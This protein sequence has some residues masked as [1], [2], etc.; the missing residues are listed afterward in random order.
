MPIAPGTHVVYTVQPGDT[1]YAI[2]NRLGTSVPALVQ[3]NALYPPVTEPDLIFPGQVILARV[4]GMSQQSAVLHQVAPGDTMYRIAERYDSTVDMLA[5][6]NRLE[7]PDILSV[8]QLIFIPAFV[9]EVEPGDTLFRISRRFGLPL[10]VLMRA[11]RNRP[12]LS[13]DVIYPGFRL[14]VPLPSSTNIAVFQPLPGT[15]IVPG[16]RLSGVARA[17]EANV[18]Y[19]IRDDA[20]RVVARERAMTASEGAP[21]FG[22]FDVALQFDQPPSTP[23]GRLLVYTRS[24][25]DG[26]IQDLVEVPVVF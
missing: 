2:A 1:L 24:P 11:N 3:A 14:I 22:Q 7:R 25:R 16:M 9:Y 8:A 21:A 12:G 26:S 19:Q 20:D 18:L 10:G 15:R 17:F 23:T 13:P 5:A 4:P 6:L